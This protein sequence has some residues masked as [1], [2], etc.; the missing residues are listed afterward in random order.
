MYA[1]VVCSHEYARNVRH[2]G[3]EQ[4]LLQQSCAQL[5]YTPP[6]AAPSNESSNVYASPADVAGHCE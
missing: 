2:N 6:T 1:S 4:A 5:Q 3:T